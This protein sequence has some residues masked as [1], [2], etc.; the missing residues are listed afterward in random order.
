MPAE[1]KYRYRTSSEPRMPRTSKAAPAENAIAESPS[2]RPYDVSTR[3]GLKI[4]PEQI[5]K[6]P[7]ASASGSSVALRLVR[8]R[9]SDGV[10]ELGREHEPHA[11][12]RFAFET[13]K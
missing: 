12:E 2:R 5:A 4:A 6:M 1:C 9:R 10:A 8:E 13:R 11:L 7:A 3:S